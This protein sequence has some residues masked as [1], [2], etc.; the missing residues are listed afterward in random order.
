LIAGVLVLHG[1]GHVMGFLAA[2]TS[3]PMGFVEG[4]SWLFSS[5][6]PI[7]SVTGKIFGLFWLVAMVGFVG[8]GIG[9]L[10]GEDGWRALALAA[11]VISLLVIL[12]W[13]NAVTPGSRVG[14]LLVDVV[15][16]IVVLGWG[17]RIAESWK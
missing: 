13:W 14:A 3:I 17:N 16:L 4:K 7:D 15:T 8:A 11:A 9:I 10:T 6:V 12:P 1:L 5:G 2:W